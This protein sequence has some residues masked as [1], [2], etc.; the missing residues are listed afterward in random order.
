[1]AVFLFVTASSISG[2][3]VDWLLAREGT[4]SYL[5]LFNEVLLLVRNSYVEEV[6][7]PGLMRGAYDG[8]LGSL[9]PDSEY[10]TREQY[11][12]LTADPDPDRGDVGLDLTRRGGYLY[13]VSVLPDSPADLA[14]LVA[15]TRLRRIEGRS[16]REITLTE[17]LLM[18]RGP[19]GSEVVVQP[20]PRRGEGGEAVTLTRTRLEPPEP[21]ARREGDA[22]VLRVVQ[23]S[24]GVAEA[25][26]RL[27]RDLD[28]EADHPLLIDL[29]GNS[30]GEYDEAA[31][32]VSL[33]LDGGEVGRI[34]ERGG[35]E[36]ILTAAEGHAVRGGPV[37]ILVDR[38]T[39]GPAELV[40][41][42]LR[43]RAE[44]QLLGAQT[45]GRGKIQKFIPLNDGG[46]LRLS[47]ARCE[48]P[49]GK[50]WDVQGLVPDHS[51]EKEMTEAAEAED[52]SGDPILKR[53]L[54][55]LAE[56]PVADAA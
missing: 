39:A 42:A 33:F 38:G 2:L 55:I 41:Q 43:V 51:L 44:A 52:S 45:F 14:G 9:D 27:L 22:V 18:L 29:R 17:A 5:K 50:T 19:I 1:V 20:F 25:A 8:L 35:E 48:G 34:R 54:E 13:V 28:G 26:G 30:A 49:D 6:E 47:V 10:L 4:Y 37:G 31:R 3:T 12:L 16:T 15:G 56:K 7:M 36:R 40:A 53:A 23:L 11:R 46:L 21:S 24:P 32:L